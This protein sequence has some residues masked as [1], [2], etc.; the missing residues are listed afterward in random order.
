MTAV[1]EM[2][3]FITWCGKAF[4]TMME[5]VLGLFPRTLLSPRFVL[6]KRRI[7]S[8]SVEEGQLLSKCGG[9]RRRWSQENELEAGGRSVKQM[10]SC[11][12]QEEG[13]L[14]WQNA[15]HRGDSADL[16]L[17]GI[18]SL[19]FCTTWGG[20]HSEERGSLWLGNQG[21]LCPLSLCHRYM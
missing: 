21:L 13:L 15:K 14:S 9:Q 8:R 20:P 4:S 11:P 10:S 16:R 3:E 7:W 5:K 12:E 19:G 18:W 2:I 6:C 1:M 17:L